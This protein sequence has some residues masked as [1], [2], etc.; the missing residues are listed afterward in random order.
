ML[1]GAC[2]ASHHDD[3]HTILRIYCRSLAVGMCEIREHRRSSNPS[4]SRQG[5]TKIKYNSNKKYLS[6]ENITDV[7]VHM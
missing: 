3:K 4:K 1:H 7:R 6:V 2:T 5:H